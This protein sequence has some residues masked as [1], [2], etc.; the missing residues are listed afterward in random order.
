MVFVQTKFMSDT[1]PTSLSLTTGVVIPAFLEA[2][3]IE[4]LLKEIQ[5]QVPAAKIVVVDDSPDYDTVNVVKE[6]GHPNVTII[7]LTAKGGRGSAVL[8]GMKTLLGLDCDRIIEMDADFSH[9]PSQICPLLKEASERQLDLLVASRYLPESEIHKWSLGRRT[10]SIASNHLARFLLRVPIS[11]YTNGY[12]VYSRVAA[13]N[14]LKHCGK[15]GSG[16]IALS[17]ILVNLAYRGFRVGETPTIFTNRVRGES[18]VSVREIRS[19]LIGLG[20]IYLLKRRLT[21]PQ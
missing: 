13:E 6:Y 10:F 12:R 21:A 18:S 9:P 8:E 15:L 3:N 16:F 11:D 14:I 2:S 5:K 4:M 1:P 7:H 17:E 20:R 19:A